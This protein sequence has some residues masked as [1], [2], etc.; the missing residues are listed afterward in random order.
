MD[1]ST[2]LKWKNPMKGINYKNQIQKEI[3]N[4]NT[5][6]C[7][8]YIRFVIKDF[9]PKRIPCPNDYTGEP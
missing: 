5:S 4:M 6:I 1:F 2:C 9:S 7:C 8:K 3:E